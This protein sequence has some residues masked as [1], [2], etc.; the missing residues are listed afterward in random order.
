M[1]GGKDSITWLNNLYAIPYFKPAQGVTSKLSFI[2][3]PV[4]F[5]VGIDD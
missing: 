5:D 3:K 4:L 2:L 1:A